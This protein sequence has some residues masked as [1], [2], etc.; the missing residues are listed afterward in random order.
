MLHQISYT[1]REIFPYGGRQLTVV[2]YRGLRIAIVVRR[3]ELLFFVYQF[4]DA[5]N[6]HFELS[7]QITN[8]Q[9]FELHPTDCAIFTYP[10]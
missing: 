5:K 8:T 6:G 2:R 1:G 7:S 10:Q 4:F 3:Y 9:K